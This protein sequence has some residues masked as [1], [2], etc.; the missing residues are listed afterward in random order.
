MNEALRYA[1]RPNDF[2]SQNNGVPA[3]AIAMAR[4][5]G[6][7]AED[8]KQMPAMWRNLDEL[9][10]SDPEAYKSFTQNILAE[11]SE[12]ILHL[13]GAPSLLLS[14]RLSLNSAST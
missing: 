9:H 10:E 4:Q 1:A 6:L 11:V 13:L 5:L 3:E 14:C 12:G 7:S 2:I 8:M